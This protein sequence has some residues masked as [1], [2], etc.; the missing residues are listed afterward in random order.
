MKD[1]LPRVSIGMPTYNRPELLELSLECFRQQ[2][3]ADFELIISD[4]A[5]P[6]PEVRQLC[7][8]Y[9][10]VDSRFHYV[11][12]P[13][14]QGAEKNFWFVYYQARAPLFMWASDDDLWP[15]DFLEK[16]ITALDSKPHAS[17]WFCQIV[18]INIRGDTIR[19]YPSFTRFQSG[20][21]K[22]VDLARFLWEPEV[23]GKANLIY[24]IFRRRALADVIEKFGAFPS[25]WG[26]DM[27]FFYGYLCR[28]NLIIDDRIILQKRVPVERLD[29]ISKPRLHIY[30]REERAAY[31]KGYRR[32]AADTGYELFTAAVLFVRLVYDYC[33]SV[34]HD[35]EDWKNRNFA[36]LTRIIQRIRARPPGSGI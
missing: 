36:R 25:S 22:F 3:F 17:A 28:F 15:T 30:P 12:Q 31:F 6:N 1:L 16:G 34:R 7:E 24:A 33:C 2:T 21:L 26:S 5:S 9:A 20:V 23:M 27:V 19:S 35:Y 4:N 11:R 8:R 10:N 13:V 29:S 18:N 32:A 14:N